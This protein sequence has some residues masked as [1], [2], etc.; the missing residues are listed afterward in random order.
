[1]DTVT[2]DQGFDLSQAL[3]SGLTIVPQALD[4][5]LPCGRRVAFIL[6]T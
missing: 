6:R 2:V 5:S 1:M 3:I 4:T